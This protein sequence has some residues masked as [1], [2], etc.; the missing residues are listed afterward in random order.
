MNDTFPAD[1]DEELWDSAL[2]RADAI[3]AFLKDRTSGA[4]TGDVGGLAA[5]LGLSQATTYRLIKLFRAGGTIMSL[6]DRK[7]G[8]PER[9]RGLDETR[10]KIIRATIDG[11]FLKPTRPPFSRLV[12]EV[13]MN[14]IS[15]GL[16]ASPFKAT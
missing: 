2:R 12:R 11:F 3:R 4:V 10:E 14:C 8:R 13:Q 6:V 1:V 9:H 15:T 7:R 16:N 5:E